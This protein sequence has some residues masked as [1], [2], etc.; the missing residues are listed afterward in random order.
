MLITNLLYAEQKQYK[1]FLF[2]PE[3]LF[4]NWLNKLIQF[5]SKPGIRDISLLNMSAKHVTK[6]L[7]LILHLHRQI[8]LKVESIFSEW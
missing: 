5:D 8:F 1:H 3:L 7:M 6:I 4:H 2:N